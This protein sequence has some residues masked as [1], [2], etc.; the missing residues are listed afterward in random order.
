MT[1]GRFFIE[2]HRDE[3]CSTLVGENGI[4]E[5]VNGDCVVDVSDLLQ[6]IGVWGSTCP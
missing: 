5:D 4:P 3:T 6:I 1:S 2:R